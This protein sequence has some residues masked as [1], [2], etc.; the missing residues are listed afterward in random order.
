MIAT[1][2]SVY[3][4]PAFKSRRMGHKRGQGERKTYKDGPPSAQV[5]KKQTEEGKVELALVREKKSSVKYTQA[6]KK[7][8]WWYRPAEPSKAIQGLLLIKK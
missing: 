4:D 7:K 1:I 5:R 8:E 6:R 2:T 3:H